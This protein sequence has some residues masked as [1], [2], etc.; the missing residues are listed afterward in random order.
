M[1]RLFGKD[2]F[3]Y[4]PAQV[5]PIFLAFISIPVFTRI[6]SVEQYGQYALVISSISIMVILVRW[7]TLAIIRFYPAVAE[8]EAEVVVRTSFWMQL[9]VMAVFGATA[10]VLINIFYTNDTALKQLLNIGVFIFAFQSIFYLLV[11]VLRARFQVGMYSVFMVWEK[12]ASLGLGVLLGVGLH[13]G[14][15][16]I[17]WGMALS[18]VIALPFLWKMA[19]TRIQV[20]GPIS[21]PLLHE[22]AKYG[23]PL[24]AGQIGAWG[25][26]QTDRYLIQ[27]FHGSQAVGMYSVAYT[28]SQHSIGLL[29]TLFRQSSTPLL[30]HI[31]ENQGKDETRHLLD[32]VTRLYLI[33]AIPMVAGISILAEPM[34]EVLAGEKFSGGH[35]IVPWV[36]CGAFFLGLQ[37]RFNQVLLLLKRS[38]T[39]MF[40]LIVASTLNVALN[41]WLLQLFSYKVAA[42]TTFICYVVLCLTQAWSSTRYFHWSFPWR[43]AMRTILAAVTMVIGISL[44]IRETNFSPAWTLCLAIPVGIVVYGVALWSFGEISAEERRSL[45]IDRRKRLAKKLTAD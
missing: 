3:L 40:W 39:I 22:M 13:L 19:F 9:A 43:T 15:V 33:A 23:I 28:I 4:L 5:I 17:L 34:M 36:S 29:S 27:L 8:K 10:F 42:V 44:L 38:G 7:L 21:F 11:Q 32:S 24:V 18:L 14:I 41:W 35:A 20:F 30:A 6:L 26:S 16:G 31:W 1:L 37:Y 12:I 45:V 25:L 2:L